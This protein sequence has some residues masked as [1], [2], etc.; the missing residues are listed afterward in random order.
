M[1]TLAQLRSWCWPDAA[2]AGEAAAETALPDLPMFRAMAYRFS[3]RE[4]PEFRNDYRMLAMR[5]L[6]QRLAMEGLSRLFEREKLRFAPFKGAYLADACY[7]DPVL[8]SRCDID[9]L[10]PPE[11]IDR[12]LE[13]LRADGWKDPYDYRPRHHCPVMH[14]GGTALEVHLGLP[15]LEVSA[16]RLWELLVPEGAGFRHHLRPELELISLFNHAL[17]HS[18]TNGAQLVTDCCFL[19][20]HDGPP[21]W[22]LMR[23]LAEEFDA[24]SPEVLFFAFPELFPAPFMPPG[25]PRKPEAAKLLRRIVL[26][27]DERRDRDDRAQLVMRRADRFSPSWWKERFAGFAPSV[28]RITCR[29]PKQGAY[30]RLAAAY[31]RMVRDKLQLAWRGLLTRDDETMSALREREKLARMLRK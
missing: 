19:L 7:P 1:T 16:E 18:W 13:V 23:K 5:E 14:K 28:L 20:K 21:D 11:E 24:P 3:P 6:P 17:G 29:L 30:G 15:H 22:E 25:A 31:F 4:Y 2:P 26:A 12:A 8:R 10:V 27:G 9:L